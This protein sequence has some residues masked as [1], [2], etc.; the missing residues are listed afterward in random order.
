[1]IKDIS[2]FVQKISPEVWD[3]SDIVNFGLVYYLL[4][5]DIS[6]VI[7]TNCSQRRKGVCGPVRS[8]HSVYV[9]K[10]LWRRNFLS[11]YL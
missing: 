11:M 3:S 8:I 6:I 4:C 2:D 5:I 9:R 7:R 10:S 1:M